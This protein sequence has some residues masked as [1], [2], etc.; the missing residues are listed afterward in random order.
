MARA[1]CP[2]FAD[3]LVLQTT[4]RVRLCVCVCFFSVCV[5]PLVRLCL[6]RRP[7]CLRS[8][9]RWTAHH[10]ARLMSTFVAP[11]TLARCV[12]PLRLSGLLMLSGPSLC[13]FR[14]RSLS[15]DCRSVCMSCLLFILVF[16]F[17]VSSLLAVLFFVVFFSSLSVFL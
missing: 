9:S 4:R 17:V 7:L 6:L 10:G 13:V 5:V 8:P 1:C 14:S 3:A 15:S 12:E 16:E 2:P 11:L